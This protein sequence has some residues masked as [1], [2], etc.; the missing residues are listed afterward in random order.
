MKARIATGVVYS[1]TT[2]NKTKI[3]K[4]RVYRQRYFLSQKIK[5]MNL[6]NKKI[7]TYLC[8]SNHI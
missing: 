6:S 2:T 7:K 1:K 3:L 8:T 5:Y 4:Y